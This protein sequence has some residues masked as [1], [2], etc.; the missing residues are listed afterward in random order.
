MP[1]PRLPE[2]SAGTSNGPARPG[3]IP[4]GAASGPGQPRS[5]KQIEQLLDVYTQLF[6]AANREHPG[7]PVSA[8]PISSRLEPPPVPKAPVAPETLVQSGLSLMQVCDLILKQ[9]YLQGAALGVDLA[10]QSRLHFNVID[11][12]IVFLKDEKCIEVSAGD[13]IGR[14]SYRFNLTDLGRSRAREA[15][16]QCRYVGPA[17]VP[18]EDYVRQCM[19]QT[20]TGT[21][22]DPESLMAAFKDFIIRPG[23]LDELGPAVCSGKSIFVYGPPGN[24]KTI[25]A[26]GLGR[27]LNNNGGEIF[28]PY[29]IHSENSIVT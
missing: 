15:F 1:N 27:F 24:G 7:T 11:E 9:L 29:A 18:L 19:Q 3:E 12:G 8:V 2:S 17:P 16:E 14:V 20:V 28:V 22:C 10:R 5:E 4:G 13:L 25:I 21:I 23:V 26:K 6:K